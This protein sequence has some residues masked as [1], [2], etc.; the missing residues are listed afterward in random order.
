MLG[1]LGGSENSVSNYQYLDP[2]REELDTDPQW[3]E[4][5]PVVTPKSGPD[6]LEELPWPVPA[7]EEEEVEGT[8][9][10][11]LDAIAE[12]GTIEDLLDATEEDVDTAEL[13]PEELISEES[14]L[15]DAELPILEDSEPIELVPPAL[16]PLEEE[17][18]PISEELEPLDL[19]Q[20]TTN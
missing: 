8:I 15:K 9:G 11:L 12:E 20:D 16:L 14:K 17:E 18:L 4:E 5:D 7:G 13:P 3:V 1:L 2:P 10:D 6:W 19:E